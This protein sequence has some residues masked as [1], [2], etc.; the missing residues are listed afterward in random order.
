MG[1]FDE[2][3]KFDTILKKNETKA[4]SK[5]EKDLEE[6]LKKTFN[7]NSGSSKS[8]SSENDDIFEALKKTKLK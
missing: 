2:V 7:K 8:N 3:P 4:V 5:L 1:L 6:S